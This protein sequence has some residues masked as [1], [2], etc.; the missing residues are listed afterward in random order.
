MGKR[1]LTVLTGTGEI[2][3]PRECARCCGTDQLRPVHV[4]IAKE[5]TGL[6]DVVRG[7]RRYQTLGLHYLACV[8]H[9]GWA[10]FASWLTRKSP[11]PNLLRWSAYLF[12]IPALLIAVLKLLVWLALVGAWFTGGAKRNP[13][14]VAAPDDWFFPL[15][16]GACAVLLVLVVMAFRRVPVRLLKLEEDAMVIRF[17]SARYARH[18]ARVNPELV[19]PPN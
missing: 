6:G 2:Q 17:A 12:G 5:V 9:A 18:F 8:Q 4:G 1:K 19:V 7:R 15:L 14:Q 11:L 10:A 3:W 13:W 16:F